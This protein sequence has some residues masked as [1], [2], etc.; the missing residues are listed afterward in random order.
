MHRD[1]PR[2]LP[3]DPSV[4]PPLSPFLLHPVP[5]V[6]QTVSSSPRVA[7]EKV[8]P[9]LSSFLLHPVPPLLLVIMRSSPLVIVTFFPPPLPSESSW[10]QAVPLTTARPPLHKKSKVKQ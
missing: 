2:V 10:S 4:R 1:K 7:T 8:S 6:L 9:S 3:P 5:P